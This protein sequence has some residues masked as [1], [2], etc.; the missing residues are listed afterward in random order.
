MACH[1][2]KSFY[3]SN[4]VTRPSIGAPTKDRVDVLTNTSGDWWEISKIADDYV[5]LR[6]RW[7]LAAE[8]SVVPRDQSTACRSDRSE[9]D[10]R[11]VGRLG[12]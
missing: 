6:H 8:V 11:C 12:R 4:D 2:P 1:E 3:C 5:Q 7:F 9:V 10:D